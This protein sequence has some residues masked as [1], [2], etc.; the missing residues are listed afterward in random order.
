M[1]SQGILS[2]STPSHW[3]Y[4][5]SRR[6]GEV[7]NAFCFKS[8]DLF[9]SVSKQDACFT[10]VEEDGGDKRLVELELACKEDGVAPPD[11]VS[12]DHG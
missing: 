11:P 12:S 9:F 2:C 4:A 1:D 6:Y 3:S 10:V 8:L 7:R 5:H